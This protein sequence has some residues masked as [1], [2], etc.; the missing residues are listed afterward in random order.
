M[1]ISKVILQARRSELP[2]PDELQDHL[3]VHHCHYFLK[4][5]KLEGVCLLVCSIS[6]NRLAD[7]EDDILPI[8][9]DNFKYIAEL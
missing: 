4:K 6:V 7:N 2:K 9:C 1:P 3:K 5:N 8:T